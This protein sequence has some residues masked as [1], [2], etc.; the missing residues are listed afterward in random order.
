VALRILMV[1]TANVCRSPMAAALLQDHLQ[2]NGIEAVVTSAGTHTGGVLID[3]EAVIAMEERG[4]DITAHS[5]RPLDRATVDEDGADLVVAMTRSQLRAVAVIGPGVFQRSFTAKELARRTHRAMFEPGLDAPTFA[6]WRDAVGEGRL[7]RDLIGDD[8]SDE[9]ADPYGES[10]AAHRSTADQ[11]DAL[12]AA[13][14]RSIALWV[15][16]L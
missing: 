9:V 15:S 2:A 8:P 3:Q 11:L 13:I 12:M 14:T 10:L 1:C 7:A 5:P 6:A 16:R 4:L